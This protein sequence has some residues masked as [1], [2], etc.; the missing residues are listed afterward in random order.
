MC[1][2]T[3]SCDVARPRYL[4]VAPDFGVELVLRL[5]RPL[6]LDLAGTQ[7]WKLCAAFLGPF[8]FF[9]HFSRPWFWIKS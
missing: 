2:R 4:E 8:Y 3:E 7:I 5:P 9:F 1:H 6:P